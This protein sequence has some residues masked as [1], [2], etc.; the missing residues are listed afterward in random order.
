MLHFDKTGLPPVK[1]FWS[2]TLYNREGFFVPNPLNRYGL[3]DRDPLKFNKDGSLDLYL[4]HTKPAQDLGNNWLP[5]PNDFFSLSLRLYWPG[6]EVLSG[7]WTPP[8]IR[9]VE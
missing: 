7:Q 6:A 8:V 2:L 9:R 5:T 1:A 3:G 4:Q